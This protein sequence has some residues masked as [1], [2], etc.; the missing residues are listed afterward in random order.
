MQGNDYEMGLQYNRKPA[1]TATYRFFRTLQIIWDLEGVDPE[2]VDI[3]RFYEAVEIDCE[4]LEDRYGSLAMRVVVNY[5]NDGGEDQDHVMW[6][7]IGRCLPD[8]HGG[9]WFPSTEFYRY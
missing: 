8:D 5:S 4:V 3:T 7:P 2:D 6:F 1:G 9:D